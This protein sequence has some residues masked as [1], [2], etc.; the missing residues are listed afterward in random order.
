MPT[1]QGKAAL[2]NG[3]DKLAEELAQMKTPERERPRW[4]FIALILVLVVV[5]VGLGTWQVLRLEEK[6]ALI[7]R[8]VDRAEQPP[9]PLPPAPEWVGFDPE[10]WDYRHTSVTGTYRND[11]TILVFTSLSEARGK[12]EG[13][14]YWVMTPMAVAGGGTVWINRGFVPEALKNAFAE[15]GPPELGSVTVSGILRRPERANMFTP[16]T[17]RANRIDWIRDPARFN[18]I[19]DPQLI[20]VLGAYL[21]ADAGAE[22]SLPQAGET[23]FDLPNR[24]FEYAL[25]WYGLAAVMLIMLGF[26]LFTRRKG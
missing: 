6:E 25:T 5:C 14:G 26:W 18:A 10:T 17:E 3:Y 11:Q 20:P 23:K 13:L 1:K 7:A 19:S 15:G 8:I 22:G 2:S 21:D 16:G 12:S 9:Q 24:H 4:S